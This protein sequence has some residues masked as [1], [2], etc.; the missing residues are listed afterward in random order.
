M[1]ES[2]FRAPADGDDVD[3]LLAALSDCARGWQ[4]AQSW[5]GCLEALSPVEVEAVRVGQLALYDMCMLLGDHIRAL[6]DTAEAPNDELRTFLAAWPT[7]A[8]S[9]LECPQ[10]PAISDWLIEFLRHE[11]WAQPLTIDDA[12]TLRGLL[13]VEAST[14][15]ESAGDD[16]DCNVI[17]DDMY[18]D[19][20]TNLFARKRPPSRPHTETPLPSP[21]SA[22]TPA[23]AVVRIPAPLLDDLLQ[24]V[25]ET[26]ILTGQIQERLTVT[27]REAQ[28]MHNQYTLVQQPELEMEEPVDPQD[29]N[30]PRQRTVNGKEFDP[31]ELEQYDE[32]NTCSRRLIEAA[33]DTRELGRCV[34]KRLS[35][36]DDMIEQVYAAC[37]G[38]R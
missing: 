18:V 24:L 3:G 20:R 12:D 15:A 29:L 27:M 14:G 4:E 26:I 31:L 28:V 25:S 30:A 36:L 16:D 37:D 17:T 7:L 8:G 2:A 10:D 32:L 38:N 19:V 1:P 11:C 23:N 34:E 5:E 21:T 35:E 33:A 9:W 6:S 22:K 13:S